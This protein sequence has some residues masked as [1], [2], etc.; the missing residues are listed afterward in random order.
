MTWGAHSRKWYTVEKA[1]GFAEFS[2]L[3]QMLPECHL[4]EGNICE[5]Q[6][7]LLRTW[8]QSLDWGYSSK[9]SISFRLFYFNFSF[10][11]FLFNF[12]SMRA[13]G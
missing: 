12:Y 13:F 3:F 4:L 6:L 2:Q 7:Y 1:L 9:Y 5:Y 8:P 10:S 11:T